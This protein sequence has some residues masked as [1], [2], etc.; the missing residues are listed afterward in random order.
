MNNDS[1]DIDDILNED[2]EKN[3]SLLEKKINLNFSL[4]FIIA[5]V[6]ILISSDIF[7]EHVLA[8]ISGCVDGKVTNW[9]NMVKTI[10]MVLM[11]GV[12]QTV[13]N[14]IT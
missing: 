8:N 4:Y 1:V 9:G 7:E 3:N 13:Q 2:V 5:I 10:M 12:G 14:V 11:V 6:F